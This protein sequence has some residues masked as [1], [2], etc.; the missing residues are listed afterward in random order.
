MPRSARS[1]TRPS[2]GATSSGS[3]HSPTSPRRQGHPHRAR[4]RAWHASTG[5]PA[6]S[7]RITEVASSTASHASLDVLSGG[8]RGCRGAC[9]ES[10]RRRHSPGDGRRQGARPRRASG[11]GRPARALG[12]RRRRRGRGAAG[13]RASRGETELWRCA[14]R[15][16]NPGGRHPRPRHVALRLSSMQRNVPGAV[17][18]GRRRSSR[19]LS[20]QR[21]GDRLPVVPKL[22]G[23]RSEVPSGLST[24]TLAELQ[25]DVPIVTLSGRY[26]APTRGLSACGTRES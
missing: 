23:E 5:R 4:T 18:A 9:T 12:A 17:T 25:H 24:D 2:R 6:S 13:A 1:S 10:S 26:K 11:P 8:R 19:S 3:P 15:L 20:R 16:P 21:E 7:S 14:P 22:A